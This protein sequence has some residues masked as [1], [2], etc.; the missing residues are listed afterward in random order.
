MPN[1]EDGSL[2]FRDSQDEQLTLNILGKSN[3]SRVDF[4]YELASCSDRDP[5]SS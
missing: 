4:V 3:N 1:I 2:G 5:V